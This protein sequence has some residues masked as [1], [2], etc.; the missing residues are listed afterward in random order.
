VRLTW[1]CDSRNLA[2]AR[3]AEKAGMILEAV[4]RQDMLDVDGR[5]RDT[6]IYA[7]LKEEWKNR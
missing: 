6:R 3:T 2:S 1:H 5:R 4:L 7:L